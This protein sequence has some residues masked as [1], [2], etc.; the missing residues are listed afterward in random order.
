ME[1]GRSALRN[2]VFNVIKDESGSVESALVMIPLIILFL[3]T[4]QLIVTVNFRNVDQVMI[5]NQ[6][7]VQATRQQIFN[8]DRLVNLKSY[9]I[10]DQLRL[11]IVSKKHEVPQIFPW[12]SKLLGGK[13]LSL[14]GVAVLE[15]PEQCNGGYLVC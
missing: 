12:V 5:Q 6:A 8:E 10:F 1:L 4:L 3:I 15:E 2:R 11:L 13:Q 14:S 9:D 7:R